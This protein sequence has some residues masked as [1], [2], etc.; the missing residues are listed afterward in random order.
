MIRK[1][2]YN[3][4]SYF[5][6]GGTTLYEKIPASTSNFGN[7]KKKKKKKTFIKKGKN[8][9]VVVLNGCKT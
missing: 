3:M 8:K 6:R 4:G 2:D 7:T 9:N 1:R 5:L